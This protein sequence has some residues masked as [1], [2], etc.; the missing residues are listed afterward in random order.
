M[1][2][3]TPVKIPVSE[4]I[5]RISKPTKH[6]VIKQSAAAA[7]K[8][9]E[10]SKNRSKIAYVSVANAISRQDTLFRN[11]AYVEIRNM[12]LGARSKHDQLIFPTN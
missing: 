7:E 12:Q 2:K 11:R 10:L 4:V 1:E 6:I 9:G 8:N 5:K 3:P